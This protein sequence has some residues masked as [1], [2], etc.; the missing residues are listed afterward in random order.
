M[1]DRNAELLAAAAKVDVV[2]LA[3]GIIANPTRG[4][5][6]ASQ[7]GTLAL[8]IAFEKSWAVVIEAD[9]LVRALKMPITGNDEND[10]VRDHAVQAQMDAVERL[11]APMR[12]TTPTDKET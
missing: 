6:G 7:A 9:L 5:I 4:A 12:Q 3:G 10:A 8:A 11:I 1:T 2:D